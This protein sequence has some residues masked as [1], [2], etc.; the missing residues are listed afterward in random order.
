VL[1]NWSE[2]FQLSE[3]N[4]SKIGMPGKSLG[5]MAYQKY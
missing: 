4:K 5:I 3:I 2:E 1:L